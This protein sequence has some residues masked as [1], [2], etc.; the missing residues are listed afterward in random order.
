MKQAYLALQENEFVK[1]PFLEATPPFVAGISLAKLMEEGV[2]S[3]GFQA[4]AVAAEINRSLYVHQ[5]TAFRKLTTGRKNVIV[6]TGTGSGK[7]ECFMY[8][9]FN[10]LMLQQEAKTLT[11]GI[12]AL[13]LYPMNALANDQMKRLR[14]LLANY[15]SIT[16]GRYTGETLEKEEKAIEAYR[17]KKEQE[18]K[19]KNKRK[20]VD[21][22]DF[23]LNPLPNEL[24]SRQK[25]RES[26][27]NI[28]LTNY[29]MLEYLLI[30]PEDTSFF[31]GDLAKN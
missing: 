12:R 30:R 17:E 16:F 20:G 1:G 9:I 25:M 14:E 26:P 19:A 31:D 29:A 3:Q 27:P 28:L 24:I 21:Y 22:T 8:P 10:E 13:L 7:T 18:F 5:E 4:I 2:A 23:D 15:P 6:A 11:P